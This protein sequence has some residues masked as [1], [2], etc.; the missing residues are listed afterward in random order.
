VQEPPLKALLWASESRLEPLLE[1]RLLGPLTGLLG[2]S[3]GLPQ[4]V[5]TGQSAQLVQ[6]VQ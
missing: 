2:A 1:L 5:Q 6:S 3:A 4:S